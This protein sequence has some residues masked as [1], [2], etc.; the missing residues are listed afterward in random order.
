[1]DIECSNDLFTRSICAAEATGLGGQLPQLSRCGSARRK[2][3][4]PVAWFLFI[5]AGRHRYAHITGV[6]GRAAPFISIARYVS[7]KVL[8]YS[9]HVCRE[10]KR[11]A[12]A[13]LET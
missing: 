2:R 13:S 3:D 10:A 12:V 8:R 6:R 11:K 1:M 7:G 5:F 9:S 4:I